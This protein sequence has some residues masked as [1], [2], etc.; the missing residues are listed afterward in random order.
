MSKRKILSK[1]EL[2]TFESFETRREELEN[3][4]QAMIRSVMA[5]REEDLEKISA[6][7]TEL[8]AKVYAKYDLDTVNT[9]WAIHRETGELKPV[10]KDADS[11]EGDSE[12]EDEDGTEKDC[13]DP[14]CIACKIKK[15]IK[16]GNIG[17]GPGALSTLLRSLR[18]A[19]EEARGNVEETS[20]DVKVRIPGGLFSVTKKGKLP[21][22]H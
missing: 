2:T 8:W 10:V 1:E 14:N 19:L 16:S 5:V 17:D 15:L 11:S 13:G 21:T 18:S 9:T 22:T 3:R 20:D 6:E 7:R 4:I 12:N